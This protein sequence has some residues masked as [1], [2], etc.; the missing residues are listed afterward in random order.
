MANQHPITPPP[1]L[2]KQWL[3]EPEYV[4]GWNGKC[5]ML[6]ITDYRFNNICAKAA[7]WGYQQA[8]EELE[9]FL[10]KSNDAH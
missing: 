3:A 4:S 1:E 10:K 8:V 7:Q 2:V 5:V 9:T 6:S